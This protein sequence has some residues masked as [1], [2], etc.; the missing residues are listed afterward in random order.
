MAAFPRKFKGDKTLVDA[1][2][3]APPSAVLPLVM[4]YRYFG[5]SKYLHA[6]RKVI[7]YQEKEII[8]QSDYFLLPLMRIVKTRKL[9]CTP[10][11]LCTTWPW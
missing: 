7:D 10:P 4:A 6:A 2:G 1:V 3:G 8:S 11:W 5:D 9:L